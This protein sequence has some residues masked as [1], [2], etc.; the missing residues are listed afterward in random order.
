M[1]IMKQRAPYSAVI[2]D[3]D[4]VLVDTEPMHLRALNQVLAESGCA[5][6]EE[7]NQQLLGTSFKATWDFVIK[8][9]GLDAEPERYA[10]AYDEAV[11]NILRQ[12]LTPAVGSM[13]LLGQLRARNMP[14]ALASSAKRRWIEATLDSLG[15]KDFFP[16]T[17]SGE[18]VT[19]SKPA[20]DIFLLAARR[21]GVPAQTCLVIED[22]PNGITAG[23]SAG[24]DVIAVRTPNTE[25]LSLENATRIVDSLEQIDL[26]AL[27]LD[28]YA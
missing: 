26:A 11:V 12:P 17:V 19:E 4:G 25:G 14:M 6:S 20:P 1:S 27:G 5:L 18:D 28:N 2:F 10:P 15:M 23:R 24:M 7:E 13:N 21:L 16:I 3:M 22:S 8:R 9:F